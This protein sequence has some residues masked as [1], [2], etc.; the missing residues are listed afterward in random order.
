MNSS[1]QW[2]LD[3]WEHIM[4]HAI[5]ITNWE[6]STP[7][8]RTKAKAVGEIAYAEIERIIHK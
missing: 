3:K 6:E 1:D 7:E 2:L 4:S 8:I 5:Q